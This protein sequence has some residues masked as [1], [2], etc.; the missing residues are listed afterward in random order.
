MA[1]R[2][3]P[4]QT[5]LSQGVTGDA[6]SCLNTF[7]PGTVSQFIRKKPFFLSH[8]TTAFPSVGFVSGTL[9]Q[10]KPQQTSPGGCAGARAPHPDKLPPRACGEIEHPPAKRDEV[11]HRDKWLNLHP[12]GQGLGGWVRASN[13]LGKD[14]IQEHPGSLRS[15]RI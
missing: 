3:F 14:T 2:S 1:R 5:L 9:N 6:T 10:G 13:H 8:K 15:K 12:F 11:P 7:P 4:S